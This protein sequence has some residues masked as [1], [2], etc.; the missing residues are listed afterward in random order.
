VNL[1]KRNFS[2]VLDR[3]SEDD[4]ALTASSLRQALKELEDFHGE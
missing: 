2:L 4:I 1:G 3:M